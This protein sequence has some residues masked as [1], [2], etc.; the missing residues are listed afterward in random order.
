M[1]M[2][3]AH[4][5]IDPIEIRRAGTQPALSSSDTSST[6]VGFVENWNSTA[7]SS[8]IIARQNLKNNKQTS[9]DVSYILTQLTFIS[10]LR[11]TNTRHG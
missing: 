3:I 5:P 6:G 10:T 4:L 11:L 1:H 8:D 7:L 2:L 9:L